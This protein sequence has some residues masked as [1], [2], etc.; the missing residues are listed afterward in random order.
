[1]IIKVPIFV[2]MVFPQHQDLL[3]EYVDQLSV[4]FTKILGHSLKLK[5]ELP[6]IVVFIDPKKKKVKQIAF[7]SKK[8][9]LDYL[10]TA[11]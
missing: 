11:K 6:E 3:G 5:E 4:H 7:I 9:A 2:E 10:R 1:M 8:R